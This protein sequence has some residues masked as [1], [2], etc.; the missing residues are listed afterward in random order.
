MSPTGS[1]ASPTQRQGTAPRPHR[2]ALVLLFLCTAG[3][4]TFLDVSIVNVA[5]P[6][7]ETELG[8]SQTQLQYVV[9][10]YGMVLGGFLMLCGRLADHFGRRRMLQTGLVI[11]ALSSL[12]AGLAQ[13]AIPLIAARGVQGLGAAFIATAAL[14]LLTSTFAEGAERNRALGAWGALS[15]IAAVAGVTLGGLITDGPGWRWIFFVNV[16]IGLLGAALAPAIVRESRSQQ[17]HPHLNVSGAALLTAGLILLIFA[18]GQSISETGSR[19]GSAEVLGSLAGA[20]IL[21]LGFLLN[22]RRAT[23]P[24]IPAQILQSRA[25]RAANLVAVL[26]LGTVV[27]LF[28]FASLFMQQVLNY[29]PTQ[30]GL[31]YLPLAITTAAGA[32]IASKLVTRIAAK[33]VLLAGLALATFGLLLLWRLPAEGDYLT[34]VLPAFLLIGLGLGLSFVPVQVAAFTGIEQTESGGVAAGLINTSQEAGGAL[35]LAVVS[36]VAFRRVPEPTQ[37]AGGD[38][39]LVRAAREMVFHDAFLTGACLLTTAFVASL[40]LLPRLGPRNGAVPHPVSSEN[41]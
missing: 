13:D 7:I 11:F 25:L 40:L 35:G 14:S 37:W 26:L 1:P 5:L 9:T 17:R 28:F 36:T 29:T 20:G 8:V 39:E 12:L 32:G 18:L 3:F 15:G 19:W 33:P 31:A 23:A 10:T 30:A 16:P 6:T 2:P 27:S 41:P 38:P 4:V 24:L 21:L 22:Q 34:D